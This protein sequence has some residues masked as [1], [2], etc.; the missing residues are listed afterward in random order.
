MDAELNSYFGYVLAVILT[1]IA[2]IIVLGI[3]LGIVAAIPELIERVSDI[4]SSYKRWRKS[5]TPD[6][7]YCRTLD[8][9]IQVCRDKGSNSNLNVDE[10]ASYRTLENWLI[11][12]KYLKEFHEN[13]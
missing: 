7:F 3:I 2:V 10:R 4:K 12:Y 1:C 11:E 13:K 5:E 6:D 9:A 8:E